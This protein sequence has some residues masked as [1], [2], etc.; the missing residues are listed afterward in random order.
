MGA[1][2][3]Q[4]LELMRT[5]LELTDKSYSPLPLA[6]MVLFSMLLSSFPARAATLTSVGNV[7][8]VGQITGQPAV[9]GTEERWELSGTD[10]GTM[11]KDFSG[12]VFLGGCCSCRQ[13]DGASVRRG[14]GVQQVEEAQPLPVQR[15][16]L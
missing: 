1:L 5:P 15:F 4:F 2:F 9:T 14:L 13:S 8:Y 3:A 7:Y 11:F 16:I 10:I 12:G 6:S